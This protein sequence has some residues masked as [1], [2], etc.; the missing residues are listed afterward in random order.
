MRGD[1]GRGFPG[2]HGIPQYEPVRSLT[3]L[4]DVMRKYAV[5]LLE[6]FG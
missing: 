5:E 4:R 2:K 6:Q 3:H 1:I